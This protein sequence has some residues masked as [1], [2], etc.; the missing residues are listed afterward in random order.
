MSRFGFLFCT[1]S[2][3]KLR[4]ILA[5]FGPNQNPMFLKNFLLLA[6]LLV[7]FLAQSQ[8]TLNSSDFP[9][10]GEVWTEYLDNEPDSHN[11]PST[12]PNQNWNY[13]AAFSTSDSSVSIFQSPAGAWASSFF[14]GANLAV[15]DPALDS[16]ASFIKTRPDGLYLYGYFY[17]SLN[18]PFNQMLY[19]PEELAFPVGLAPGQKISK[20]SR[21]TSYFVMGQDSIMKFVSTSQSTF[22][23]AGWGLLTTPAAS[24]VPAI[25]LKHRME[26]VDSTFADLGVGQY[27]FISAGSNPPSHDFQFFKKGPGMFAMQISYDSVQSMSTGAFYTKSGT[28]TPTKKTLANESIRIF[29]NP[30]GTGEINFVLAGAAASVLE[31]YSLSGKRILD[32]KIT[33]ASSIRISTGFLEAG[34]YQFRFLDKKNQMIHSGKFSVVK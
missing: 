32:Q 5:T 19:Q 28:V 6:F 16:S 3:K 24:Q 31:V 1:P 29:P 14:P 20:T 15:V 30:S 13:G 9:V 11:F 10:P 12:G 21:R 25:L 27:S 23:H 7:P 34:M 18:N 17:G 33:D 2:C 26:G 22:E 4:K 8:I